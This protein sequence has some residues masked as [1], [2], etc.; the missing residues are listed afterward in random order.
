MFPYFAITG[1]IALLFNT[2]YWHLSRHLVNSY[3][4]EEQSSERQG[5]YLKFIRTILKFKLAYLSL[6][7]LA[8]IIYL[9]GKLSDLETLEYV[10]VIIDTLWL[11]FSFIIFTL[12][13]YA[14]KYPELLQVKRKYQDSNFNQDEASIIQS[15][16]IEA[17][18]VNKIYLK[19][20]LTLESVAHSIPTASHTLSRVINE[21]FHQ[22]F[23]ELINSY[24]I[25]AF[26][27]H[28]EKHPKS[29]YLEVAFS[30]GF[31][32]KPTFNRVFKK[33]KGCTPREYFKQS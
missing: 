30:V 4:L 31:N 9:I 23:T 25:K 8:A 17:L 24:R 6:W 10:E 7:L 27:E 15:K 1:A 21:K 29:S 3:V 13:F 20:D 5:R 22:N 11:A 12:A 33:L 19:S 16:L 26:I 28:V 32:S 18:T 2:V 14:L